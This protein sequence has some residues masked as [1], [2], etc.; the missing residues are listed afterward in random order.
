MFASPQSGVYHRSGVATAVA[1]GPAGVADVDTSHAAVAVAA[2]A[3]EGT[4]APKRSKVAAVACRFARG[5]IELRRD[6]AFAARFLREGAP[7]WPSSE[8]SSERN[9]SADLRDGGW[10]REGGWGNIRYQK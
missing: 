2:A 7:S 4:D 6:G 1:D 9:L 3:V 5:E 8:S 10:G